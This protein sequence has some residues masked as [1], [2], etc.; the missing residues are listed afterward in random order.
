MV[1]AQH[2]LLD[3]DTLRHEFDSSEVVAQFVLNTGHLLYVISGLQVEW[4]VH[5]HKH[6]D[7]LVV[8]LESTH[9]VTFIKHLA[10]LG[11]VDS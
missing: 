4:S 5:L 3:D 7:S 11:C 10:T 9:H 2:L 1:S 6:T 8:L